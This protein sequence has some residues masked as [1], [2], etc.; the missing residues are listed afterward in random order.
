MNAAEALCYVL[1]IGGR[2]SF[3]RIGR[4]EDVLASS[5]AAQ[6]YVARFPSV[7]ERYLRAGSFVSRYEHAVRE[8]T[9]AFPDDT[10]RGRRVLV[11]GAGR[12]TD[13]LHLARDRE[14][15]HVVGVEIDRE[16]AAF[17]RAMLTDHGVTNAEIVHTDM[18]NV[19]QIP[20]ASFDLAVSMATFEHVMDLPRVLHETARVLRPGG[21]LHAEFSPIWR[22]YYGSHLGKYLPFPWTH[23]LF[24][25]R[26][27][28]RTLARLQKIPQPPLYRGLNRLTLADYRRI[29]AESPFRVLSFRLETRS[30]LKRALHRVPGVAEF[31]AG[32]VV[33]RLARRLASGAR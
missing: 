12:G 18:A 30:R 1:N 25:E 24:S 23:L 26:T 17:S 3:D 20:D 8:Y 31:V 11:I 19:P 15:N 14:A 5:L 29:F 32:G 7:A 13:V 28:H 27:V 21:I 4:E 9:R 6:E 10:I 22:H 2:R 33:V 16:L